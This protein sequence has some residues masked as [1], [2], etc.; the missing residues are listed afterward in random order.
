MQFAAMESEVAQHAR[1]EA[2]Q[3]DVSGSRALLA[4][5]PGD[6][7]AREVTDGLQRRVD[8]LPQLV[9][10]VRAREVVK[11]DAV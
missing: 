10:A 9:R 2:A 3:R 7:L 11:L 6:H 1:I 8:D 5:P 4:L